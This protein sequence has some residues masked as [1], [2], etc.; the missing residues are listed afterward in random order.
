LRNICWGLRPPATLVLSYS[1]I[2][3]DVV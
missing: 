2:F 1:N 3:T